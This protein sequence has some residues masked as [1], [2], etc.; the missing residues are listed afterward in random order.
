MKGISRRRGR[1]S[2]PSSGRAIYAARVL[3]PASV[4]DGAGAGRGEE[5][6]K[7]R[8][9]QIFVVWRRWQ[10]QPAVAGDERGDGE[11]RRERYLKRNLLL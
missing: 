7:G 5:N 10:Q 1:G 8:R 11:V 9:H 6:Q 3:H 2:E 4:G